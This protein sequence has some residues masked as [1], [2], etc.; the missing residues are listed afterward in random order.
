EGRWYDVEIQVRGT[1]ARC[2][3]DGQ[4]IH[5]F[6]L[7]ERQ[8]LYA[9]ATLDEKSGEIIVK[10][11]NPTRQSLP[12]SIKLNGVKATEGRSI[13]LA[14]EKG[15]D[16]NSMRAQLNVSPVERPVHF[17]EPASVVA[18]PAQPFSLTILRLKTK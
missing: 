17:S 1:S 8:G 13:V 15:S 3:L 7:P 6:S 5:E 14:S 9:N 10:L 16:E 11:V 12:T 18:V 4:L 2:L